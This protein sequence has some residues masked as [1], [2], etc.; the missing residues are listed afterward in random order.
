MKENVIEIQRKQLL[1]QMVLSSKTDKVLLSGFDFDGKM[2]KYLQ[3]LEFDE[4]R[5]VFMTRYRMLPTKVNF[6]GRWEGQLC[7]VCGFIDVDEHIFNCPGYKDLI[8]DQGMSLEM[9]WDNEALNDIEALRKVASVMKSVIE[10]MEYI[11]DMKT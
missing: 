5:A 7:N 2:M 1:N 4:A 11:Q 8:T 9:F 3:E 6:P 10:R